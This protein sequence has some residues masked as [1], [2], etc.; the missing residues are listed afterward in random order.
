MRI[1]INV[2]GNILRVHYDSSRDAVIVYWKP[3]GGDAF[4]TLHIENTDPMWQYAADIESG[5]DSGRPKLPFIDWWTAL[6]NLINEK[7]QEMLN[8]E[9]AKEY[10]AQEWEQELSDTIARLAWVDGELVV[11]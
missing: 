9:P 3:E 7:I 10:T 4:G 8:K 5:T 11:K 2:E 1:D 6:L